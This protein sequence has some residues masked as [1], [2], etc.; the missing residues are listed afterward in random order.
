MTIAIQAF[1]LILILASFVI[2]FFSARAWHWGYVLVVLG[3]FLSTLGFFVLAAE[4]LRINAVLR[5]QVNQL[6]DNVAQVEAKNEALEMGTEDAALLNQLR[7]EEVRIPEDAESMP[8]IAE[9]EHELLLE[10]RARGRM[11]WN[12]VP[13][14]FNPETGEVDVGIPRPAPAGVSEQSVVVLFEEGEPQ[15]PAPDGTPRGPQYLGEFRV[16]GVDAQSARLEPVVP[17]DDFERQRLAGS[18]G[19]WV[20]YD[21]MPA[22]RHEVI[23]R[24]SEE[25]LK[26]KLPPQSVNEYLRHGEPANPDDENIRIEGYDESGQLLP[27]DQLAQAARKVYQRRLRDYAEEFDDL[28]QRRTM[29]L[30]DTAAVQKDN[31]RLNEALA[32]G[33]ELQAYREEDLRKLNVDLAGIRKDRAAIERHLAQV[34]RHLSRGRELLAETLRRNREMVEQLNARQ[35]QAGGSAEEGPALTSPTGPLALDSRN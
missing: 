13:T 31:E 20:M 33:K 18:R 28:A 35:S 14:N 32:S 29:L 11:W 19:P 25:E 8:S 24:M 2:A 3:I 7:N 26:Q 21:T 6:R 23:A 5:N 10:T 9:L 30:V 15:L 34:E 16:V 17:L 22:D 4:T 1:L 27:R 12:V